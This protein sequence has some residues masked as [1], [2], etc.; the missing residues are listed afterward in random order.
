M[1]T[2]TLS[3]ALTR[4]LSHVTRARTPTTCVHAHTCS[5]G[6][7][8]LQVTP[9]ESCGLRGLRP[10][11]GSPLLEVLVS[12]TKSQDNQNRFVKSTAALSHTFS[13]TEVVGRWWVA[14]GGAQKKLM[15]NEEF[16]DITNR[17]LDTL[18]NIVWTCFFLAI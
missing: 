4:P 1:S 14:V 13:A 8:Y 2:Y 15:R 12:R 18:T 6:L 3:D 5:A 9:A 17:G 7:I 10:L 11:H 16:R